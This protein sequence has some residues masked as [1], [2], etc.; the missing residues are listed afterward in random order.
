MNQ[1]TRRQIG[2]AI[3]LWGRL[4]RQSSFFRWF[5]FVQE[6]ERFGEHAD[7][8]RWLGQIEIRAQ[9][10]HAL[11]CA[12]G[13]RAAF[14]LIALPGSRVVIW[15]GIL[16]EYWGSSPAVECVVTVRVEGVSQPMIARATLDPARVHRDRRWV[17][18]V[19][20][21]RN[22]EKRQIEVVLSTEMPSA[23][24]VDDAAIIWGDPQLEWPRPFSEIR[25]LLQS[26]R[27]L[28]LRGKLAAAARD[29]HGR[30]SELTAPA[31]LYQQWFARQA[32]SP[33]QLQR[34]RTQSEALRYRPLV[35]VVTPVYNT[36]PR[37]LRACIE[38][39]TRQAYSN[40]QLCIAD[41]GS[42]RPDTRR[43]LQEYGQDSRIKIA[44]LSSNGGIAAASN[45][46]VAL[47]EGE[48][49]AFLDHDDEITPEA[50]STVVACLNDHPDTDFLYSDEDKLETDGSLGG[51]YFKPDWS[52]EHL[53]NNMYTC[54][55]M[56]V[57]RSLLTRVGGFRAGYDGA[58]DY[59]L[60][61]RLM[62]QTSRI[63]HLPR[64]L[65]HWRKIPESTASAGDAKP[66]AFNAG[67][68]ALE[69][70]LRRNG[71]KADVLSTGVPGFYRTRF[72]IEGEPLISIVLA[73]GNCH[74]QPDSDARERTLHTLAHRTA[75]RRYE[76][77]PSVIQA[78]GDHL[79]FLDQGMDVIDDQWLTALLEYSQQ[80]AVGAVGGKLFDRDDGLDHL[81][82]LIGV[83]GAATSAL[84]R[85][86]RS[87][88]GYWGGAIIARNCSAVSAACLMTRRQVFDE[89]GGFSGD[90]NWFRGVDYGLR[91]RSAGYRVVFT[92][93]ATL[94]HAV[95]PNMQ[96]SVAARDE[97]RMLR[98][99]WGER[100][101]N[102]PYY[103][104]NLSRDSPYYEPKLTFTP[105]DP[106]PD[107]S[108]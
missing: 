13:A 102:D 7:S 99:I 106:Q 48:F 103:N 52:P 51:V 8:I 79:L 72:A 94:V 86:P 78:K 107:A 91:V 4:R 54:H 97:A 38:S 35:S 11:A 18:L 20:D 32:P 21:L 85:H 57:R 30:L 104:P 1:S 88:L 90:L 76:V 34:L 81:G 55:L 92:P 66:F 15:C 53:R 73:P 95:Q 83:N 60:V 80:P 74:E 82:L 42:T 93:H 22:P 47:A 59:D 64:V 77:V 68:L 84:H 39:V 67:K 3:A 29:L 12:P 6:Q 46:A 23:T 37:W 17:K 100:L 2:L 65:Y 40:W 14:R 10:H 98:S 70:H 87:S 71:L 26:V 33:E 41:D 69:D 31:S 36:D 89:V 43:V 108:E 96:V 5:P 75:Y 62:D 45:A 25:Q 50:L 28:V 9:S 61:L 19:L 63:H 24:H 105:S 44:T 49:V 101:G 56:V 27:P 16:P 58:Q